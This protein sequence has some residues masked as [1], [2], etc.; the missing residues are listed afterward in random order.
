[1]LDLWVDGGRLTAAE[2]N[3][4]QFVDGATGRVAARLEVTAG[5][6]ITAPGGTAKIDFAG[7]AGARRG[8]QPA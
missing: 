3:V 5:A 4:L 6:P 8:T 1:M 7:L 2:I